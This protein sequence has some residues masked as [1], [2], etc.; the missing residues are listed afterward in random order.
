MMIGMRATQLHE[1]DLNLLPALAALLDERSVTGAAIRIH[2]SQSA[3]SRSLSRLRRL[4]NDE[5]LVRT[6]SGYQLTARAE[7]LRAQLTSLQPDLQRLF[8]SEAFDPAEDDRT[9]RMAGTDYAAETFATSLFAAVRSGSPLSVLRWKAWHPGI[10]EELEQDDLDLAFYGSQGPAHLHHEQLF[11]DDFV[12]VLGRKHRYARR[13]SLPMDD[14]VGCSHVVVDV[15]GGG[16]PAVE[17]YLLPKGTTR[18]AALTVPYHVA[19]VRAVY[20]TDLVATIPRRMVPGTVD[21]D[22]CRVLSAPRE[23]AAMDYQML[24]HPRN[25]EDPAHRW[26]RSMVRQSV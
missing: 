13:R 12:C 15:I 23:I 18:T 25:H 8:L 3:M 26:L 6:P 21:P 9:W 4:F 22:R 5:L 16:Q 20:S 2:L 10:F 1:V 24:W 7:T 14:Y 17:K 11:A 19:A